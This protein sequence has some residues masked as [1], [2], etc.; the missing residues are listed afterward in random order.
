MIVEEGGYS[1]VRL[2]GP[3]FSSNPGQLYPL[4]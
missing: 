4:A 1:V 3:I 2:H